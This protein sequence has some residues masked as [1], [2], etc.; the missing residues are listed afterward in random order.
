M[1]FKNT[2]KLKKLLRCPDTLGRIFWFGERGKSI[3]GKTPILQDG[4]TFV[5]FSDDLPP[6][7]N[8]PEY[9]S[10]N[11]YQRKSLEL[12]EKYP[13]GIVVDLGA[14]NPK[15]SFPNVC[16]VEIRKYPHTDIVISEGKV[17][18]KSNS[19]DAVISESVLEHVKDP[20]FYIAEIHRIL[21]SDGEV[22]LDTAFMQPF[23]AYPHHYFNTTSSAVRMLFEKFNI[24]TL[25]V[26][27]HQHPWLTLQWLLNSFWSGIQDD[28]NREEFRNMTIGQAIDLLNGL[29]EMRAKIKQSDD[30]W[31]VADHLKQFNIDNKDSLKC[32]INLTKQCEEE[33]AAGFQVIAKKVS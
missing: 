12:I 17:P 21:K 8:S 15:K 4:N 3:L 14:G 19:V 33:L 28:S 16:Q 30:P 20:F 31:Q 1:A 29:Q 9:E 5:F 23:H 25:H 24:E 27:P 6:N 18:L 2:K 11:P 10:S 13:D 32:F 22:L 26:G 7:Y